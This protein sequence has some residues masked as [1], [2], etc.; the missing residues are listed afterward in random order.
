M[1]SGARAVAAWSLTGRGKVRAP[2]GRVVANGDTFPERGAMESATETQTADGP[3]KGDQARVKRR[4]KSPPPR[5]R[6]RGQGKP[7]PEKG[8]ID[9]RRS[10]AWGCPPDVLRKGEA[11]YG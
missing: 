1:K 10:D 4:G 7:H 6:H 2:K 5:W 3:R 9:A 11:R 8:R